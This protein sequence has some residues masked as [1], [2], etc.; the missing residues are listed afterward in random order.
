M[1][2]FCRLKQDLVTLPR[3]YSTSSYSTLPLHHGLQSL[4]L[5]NTIKMVITVL[6]QTIHLQFYQQGIGSYQPEKSSERL[7]RIVW[8]V[9]EG[10]QS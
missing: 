10:K 8:Y 4:S 9:E 1:Q 3:S 2:N 7:K 6:V 5:N